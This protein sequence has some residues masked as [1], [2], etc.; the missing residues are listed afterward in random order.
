[1]YSSSGSNLVFAMIGYSVIPVPILPQSINFTFYHTARKL[2]PQCCFRACVFLSTSNQ[3]FHTFHF[4]LRF[5]YQPPHPAPGRRLEVQDELRLPSTASLNS[6]VKA[7]PLPHLGSARSVRCSVVIVPQDVASAV[8][9][10]FP[11]PLP[12]TRSTL[13]TAVSLTEKS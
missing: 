12:S 4:A 8:T 6:L 2:R 1:M 3:S 5:Y 10:P 13:C 9:Q 11:S 7:P